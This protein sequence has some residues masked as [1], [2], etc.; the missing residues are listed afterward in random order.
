MKRSPIYRKVGLPNQ[1]AQSLKMSLVH[2]L[3][4]MNFTKS[5]VQLAYDYDRFEGKS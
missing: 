5:S 3:E 1:L 2:S 4:L